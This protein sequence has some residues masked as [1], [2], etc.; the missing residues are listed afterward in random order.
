MNLFLLASC[1]ICII[2]GVILMITAAVTG[3][4]VLNRGGGVLGIAG[5]LGIC[6]LPF[7]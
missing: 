7:I 2:L 4:E 5:A 3:S 6:I 1:I